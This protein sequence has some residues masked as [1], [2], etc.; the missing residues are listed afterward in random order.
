MGVLSFAEVVKSGLE[1]REYDA[2]VPV[3]G[4]TARLD[5]RMW[6]KSVNLRCFFTNLESG[7][8][9]SL[10]AFRTHRGEHHHTLRE[11]G[12]ECSAY[13]PEDEA[14]DFAYGEYDGKL[15]RLITRRGKRGG[16]LW[17]SAEMLPESAE[18]KM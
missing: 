8:K 3:G 2:V 4:I 18:G 7:E 11:S 12:K 15:F 9:F 13:T 6:G 17:A 1:P 10:S 16:V 5:F 14:I